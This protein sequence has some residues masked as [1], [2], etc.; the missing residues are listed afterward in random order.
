M[1]KQVQSGHSKQRRTSGKQAQAA[2]QSSL[3]TTLAVA[4]LVV[5]V[6]LAFGGYF[7]D[8]TWTGF[9]GNTLWDWLSLLVLPVTLTT[10]ATWFSSGSAWRKEWNAILIVL[11]IALIILMIGGY[12]MNWAWTGFQGNTLWDW[13]KLLLLPVVLTLVTVRISQIQSASA[14]KRSS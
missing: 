8:W 12:A 14:P 3:W 10:A 9:Q 5:L 6:L 11:T 2:Q 7:F 4:S 1:S 13:L